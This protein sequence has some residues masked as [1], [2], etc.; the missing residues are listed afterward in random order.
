[1]KRTNSKVSLCVLL[2]IVLLVIT[3]NI[4]AQH[5]SP[6]SIKSDGCTEQTFPCEINTK[7][8]ITAVPSVGNVFKTWSDGNTEN[9]RTLIISKDTTLIAFFEFSTEFDT[10][11]TSP[12]IYGGSVTG[13]G[14]YLKGQS[15]TLTAVPDEGF[16]FVQWLD[17]STENPRQI[18]P[19]GNA[20]YT[21][22][23]KGGTGY[24][25]N[26]YADGCT[27]TFSEKVASGVTLNLEAICGEHS[28]FVQWSDGVKDIGRS[29]VVSSDTTIYAIFK[30][31]KYQ[32]VF[33]NSNG[34]ILQNTEE[35]YGAM[36]KYNGATPV[37]PTDPTRYEFAGW[38]PDLTQV[39]RTALYTATYTNIAELY[40][41]TLSVYKTDSWGTAIGAG[42][43]AEGSTATIE[44][45]PASGYIF[46]HWYNQAEQTYIYE[47]PYSFT[48][49]ASLNLTASFSRP[50]KIKVNYG[51]RSAEVD[52]EDSDIISVVTSAKEY[53]YVDNS[54]YHD[55]VIYNMAGQDVVRQGQIEHYEG[56][57]PAGVYVIWVD[58]TMEKFIV[59]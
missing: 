16:S 48:V 27:S 22:V 42:S 10:I 6:V 57:L 34:S 55:I 11:T 23:F 50:P 40:D 38:S 7:L 54:E 1:M 19:S 52:T 13:T 45:I 39:T 18:K 24:K 17:G 37:H 46:S 47:N 58:D 44:A 9:P 33:V 29:V 15:I 8:N 3:Q 20:E 43:Y 25:V 56:Y 12:K 2:Q 31:E 35:Y 5:V 14:I 36:P 59:Y 4:F 51:S 28:E 26:I 41:I 49:E 32:V 53:V 30:V 21:P